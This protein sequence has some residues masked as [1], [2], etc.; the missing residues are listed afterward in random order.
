MIR[1]LTTDN[2]NTYDRPNDSIA[3]VLV[4]S[5]DEGSQIFVNTGSLRF[6]RKKFTVAITA[7]IIGAVLILMQSPFRNQ[8][9]T[10]GPLNSAHAQIIASQTGDQCSACHDVG[11]GSFGHWLTSMFRPGKNV[12]ACQSQLCMQ[13][14]AQTIVEEFA[15]KPHNLSPGKLRKLSDKYQNKFMS[16]SAN[17]KPPIDGQ[18]NIECSS[19][20][21]EHHGQQ[22]LMAMTD[23]QCQTCHTE[24]YHSFETNHPEFSN[25][26]QRRRQR[27]AFDHTSHGLKHFPGQNQKFDCSICHVDDRLKSVK[28]LSGYE[29]ACAQCHQKE[30]NSSCDSGIQLIAVPMLDLQAISD[31]KLDVGLWPASATGDFDG[32]VPEL[33]RMLLFKDQSARKV[34]EKHGPE[35]EFGDL[36]PSDAAD[37]EDAVTLA[38]AIKYLIFDLAT[39]GEAEL[40]SRFEFALQRSISESEYLVVTNGLE[41]SVFAQAANHWLPG[42]AAEIPNH[43]AR[44]VNVSGV[45]C[46][47]DSHDPFRYFKD[48]DPG[49]LK[50]NPLTEL[51]Q[52]EQRTND[53]G[54]FENA[55]TN[56]EFSVAVDSPVT[57]DQTQYQTIQDE[58]TNWLT[59]EPEA[60]DSIQVTIPEEELLAKNPIKKQSGA[61]GADSVSNNSSSPSASAN[62]VQGNRVP[63]AK[64]KN[65]ERE[66]SAS[67]GAPQITLRRS[68]NSKS[69]DPNWLAPN[70]LSISNSGAAKLEAPLKNNSG[71]VVQKPESDLP[72]SLSMESEEQLAQEFVDNVAQ[73]KES[74]SAKSDTDRKQFQIESD[75]SEQFISASP[76]SGWFRN[77]QLFQISYRSAGHADKFLSTM[78]E[79]VSA[80]ENI[81]SNPAAIP[82]FKKM[83]SDSSYGACNKCHT[84]DSMDTSLQVNWRSQ[85]RDP[86]VRSFTRFSHGPHLNQTELR[87]CTACHH[88]EQSHANADTFKHF[89]STNV[90]SN[91]APIK[92]TNCTSCHFKGS[93]DSS[94]TQCH[95]YHIGSRVSLDQ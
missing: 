38:W 76:K 20:H 61:T 13:C 63:R 25:W 47:M 82:Y 74:S 73:S 71:A 45:A 95:N 51:M 62:L 89:D 21:R 18:G 16:F 7:F 15:T 49:L 26:P 53:E 1:K 10:P 54:N 14:H 31:E 90:I 30:I 24:K 77:D 23:Q 39:G 88:M 86:L 12:Q 79:I 32:K 46:L 58:S 34:F 43:R 85:Y 42:L 4:Q 36:D 68:E 2:Q 67:A 75:G 59:N 66:N 19:C 56:S 94:C 17:I 91:F 28:L 29:S 37:I 72:P 33:M 27:I 60:K 64:E 44:S 84:I 3:R 78:M 41:A 11:R 50:E 5:D 48:D 9:I 35:F 93:A 8:F 81:Q 70:P 87:D 92:K 22:D 52:V 57:T 80:T 69:D 83:T 55:E 6:N 40:R 65:S